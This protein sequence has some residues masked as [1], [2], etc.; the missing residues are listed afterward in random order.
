MKFF[1]EEL[2]VLTRITDYNIFGSIVNL[3]L[4]SRAAPGFASIAQDDFGYEAVL[5]MSTTAVVER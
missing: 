3:L 5:Y 2:L 4:P 1:T